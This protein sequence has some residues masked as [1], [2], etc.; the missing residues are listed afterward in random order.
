MRRFVTGGTGGDTYT[1][2]CKL[3]NLAA[4]E[5]IECWHKVALPT[6]YEGLVKT[7]FSLLPNVKVHVVGWDFEVEHPVVSSYPT[8]ALDDGK[9]PIRDPDGVEMSWFPDFS[10]A[11]ISKFKLPTGYDVIAPISG[12]KKAKGNGWRMMDVRDVRRAVKDKT[13][14]VLGTKKLTNFPSSNVID[15]TGETTVLEAMEI[16]KHARRFVGMQGMLGFVALSMRVPSLLYVR[17]DYLRGLKL[18]R[19]IGLWK[20]YGEVSLRQFEGGK[21]SVA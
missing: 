21:K 3:L 12:G 9:R 6:H 4:R 18:R 2:M 7:I 16:V 14:V 13:C 19:V 8:G 17:K 11:D 10:F 5:P 15:L 20:E 1:I